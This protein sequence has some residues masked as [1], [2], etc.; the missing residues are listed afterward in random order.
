MKF[1]KSRSLSSS[2]K[3][4]VGKESLTRTKWFFNLFIS[5]THRP[6][7]SREFRV[8]YLPDD[9]MRRRPWN[10]D[11][12]VLR[13][14]CPRSPCSSRSIF[15]YDDFWGRRWSFFCHRVWRTANAT[16]LELIQEPWRNFGRSRGTRINLRQLFVKTVAKAEI[17]LWCN[18]S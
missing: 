3:S 17:F 11:L 1:V 9:E 4:N 12:Q 2:R 16:Q 7:F 5:T 6:Y 8:Y 13:Q 14:T 15:K 18:D 10:Y